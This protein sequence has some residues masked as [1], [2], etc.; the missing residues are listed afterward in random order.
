MSLDH[1]NPQALEP[2]IS[3]P[4][5]ESLGIK[6]AVAINKSPIPPAQ[7]AQEW[8]EKFNTAI[9][10]NEIEDV[11]KLFQ[12]DAWWR[13]LLA[14]TW[15]FR[16]LHGTAQLTDLLK[17]RILNPNDN[18]GF[19]KIALPDSPSLAPALVQ[20]FVDIIW[21]QAFV[22]FSTKVGTGE[23][24]IRLVPVSKGGVGIEWKAHLVLTVLSSLHSFPE[25]IGSLRDAKPSHSVGEK[26]WHDRRQAEVEYRDREPT[27]V[28]IGAGQCGLD[29]AARLKTIGVDTLV[30]EKLQF[31]GQVCPPFLASY[32]HPPMI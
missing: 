19:A 22:T 30:L 3:L 16:T 31:P 6:D 4:T 18:A 23:G 32:L 12:P 20:P 26:S 5:L 29:V 17:T 14:L 21:I 25:T 24:I 11:L 1:L 10:K 27:T 28:I 8:L 13:D 15:D 2:Q 9:S 7:I